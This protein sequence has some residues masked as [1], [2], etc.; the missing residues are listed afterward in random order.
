MGPFLGRGVRTDHAIHN[1]KGLGIDI[2]TPTG[3]VFSVEQNPPMVVR[4]S[5]S[6]D[7][8]TEEHEQLTANVFHE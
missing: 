5:R 2:R 6:Y 8:G 7:K 4:G 3:E 1:R